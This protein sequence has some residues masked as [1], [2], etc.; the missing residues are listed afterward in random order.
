MLNYFDSITY[1]LVWKIGSRH[2]LRLGY[3]PWSRRGEHHILSNNIISHLYNEGY[4]RLNQIGNPPTTNLWIQTWL[5]VEDFNIPE[6]LQEEWRQ[7]V[8]A[9]ERAHIILNDREDD[10]F[11]STQHM[12]SK[13]GLHF[14]RC[15]NTN[16]GS[17]VVETSGLEG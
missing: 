1:G 2:E 3:V 9:L 10:I 15:P 17:R 6:G 13:V 8:S 14:F 7:Y 12:Y 5:S 4:T 16:G 11:W